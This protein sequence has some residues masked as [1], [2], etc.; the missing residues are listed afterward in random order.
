MMCYNIC[1]RSQDLDFRN[2]MKCKRSVDKNGNIPSFTNRLS[3]KER[4]TGTKPC[5]ALSSTVEL[6]VLN[7]T[8]NLSLVQLGSVSHFVSQGRQH[9]VWQRQ[10]KK[11]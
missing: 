8:C 10:K 3:E 7:A 9:N 11:P 6:N 5:R 2:I 4:E 1:S